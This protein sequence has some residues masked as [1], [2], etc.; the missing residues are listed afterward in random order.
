VTEGEMYK[1][2]FAPG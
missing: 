1:L 2:F